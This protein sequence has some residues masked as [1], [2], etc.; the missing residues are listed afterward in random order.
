MSRRSPRA[1][2]VAQ[3][4]RRLRRHH[5]DDRRRDPASPRRL[6]LARA[7]AVAA[8]ARDVGARGSAP[9]RARM[10]FA[11][12]EAGVVPGHRTVSPTTTPSPEPIMQQVAPTAS[13]SGPRRTATRPRRP[14]GPRASRPRRAS[15][16]RSRPRSGPD[17]L[18]SFA[19]HDRSSSDA[20]QVAVERGATT[21]EGGVPGLLGHS[22]AQ[23]AAVGL[24]LAVSQSSTWC[25]Q[26]RAA[27][28]VQLVG[29]LGDGL[30]RRL[31]GWLSRRRG[32]E[33][34]PRAWSSWERR[35]RAEASDETCP[36]IMSPR[37]PGHPPKTSG[38]PTG[39]TLC[40]Y[41]AHDC[42]PVWKHGSSR[43]TRRSGGGDR[44]GDRRA[45]LVFRKSAPPPRP[46]DG[47]A[48]PDNGAI[49]AEAAPAAK[50]ADRRAGRGQGQLR[51]PEAQARRRSSAPTPR[52]RGR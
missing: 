12:I 28:Q 17:S 22:E 26:L 13:T 10:P 40:L 34:G 24:G 14:R 9:G 5:D 51:T 15:P 44:G 20:R 21:F 29:E 35:G 41:S 48:R 39:S 49:G 31:V 36:V 23:A 27:L 45:G 33:F 38:C 16:R 18:P 11:G 50:R 4:S 37:R 7:H 25:P 1:R 46:P 32:R 3:Q 8:R 52:S 42:T 30:A 19:T 43:W 47:E 6:G 2:S